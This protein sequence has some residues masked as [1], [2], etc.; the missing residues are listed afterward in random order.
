MS[1]T[2]LRT[3]RVLN[4]FERRGG[5]GEYTKPFQDFAEDVQRELG[6][7]AAI[8]EGEVPLIASYRNR[9]SW[10]LLTSRRLVWLE[11]GT[12]NSL[13]WERIKDATIPTSAMAALR[14]SVKLENAR[15][16]VLTDAGKV[17]VLVEPGK[18]FSGFWNVL[19]TVPS[20]K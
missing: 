12:R 13:P 4:I 10:V 7:G 18:P 11:G 20:L 17:E 8:Q 6:A 5:S 1:D 14:S 19:K 16:E 9:D 3:N 15:L 2:T